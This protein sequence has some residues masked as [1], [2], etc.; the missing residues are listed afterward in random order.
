[1]LTPLSDNEVTTRLAALADFCPLAQ[2]HSSLCSFACRTKIASRLRPVRLPF[3][4]TGSKV[5]QDKF[6]ERFAVGIIDA[7]KRRPSYLDNFYDVASAPHLHLLR[8]RNRPHF[9]ILVSPAIDG[10]I[11]SCVESEALDLSLYGFSPVLKEFT[12]QTKNVMS[13]KDSRFKDL[14]TALR[15]NREIKLLKSVLTYLIKAKYL[16]SDTEL[17]EIF[18]R[19]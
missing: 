18:A 10:F 14:F 7:D 5:M 13:N 1:M 4:E 17:L 6:T 2:L 9:I 15:D 3:F 12:A 16:A 19:N 8:H 11:L